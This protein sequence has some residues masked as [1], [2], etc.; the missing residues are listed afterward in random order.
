MKVSII[1]YDFR[2]LR[3]KLELK[4]LIMGMSNVAQNAMQPKSGSLKF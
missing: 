2:K 4:I 3:Q 1:T